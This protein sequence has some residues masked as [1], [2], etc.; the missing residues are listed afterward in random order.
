M[1]TCAYLAAAAWSGHLSP[2]A[3]RPLL[4]G[5]SGPIA[6][7]WVS[8]PP[9]LAS[10]NKE[11]TG[12]DFTLE[13]SEKGSR[14]GVF[15]TPDAQVT[16]ILKAGAFPPSPGGTKVQL[17][18]EPI[19]P[20]TLAGGPAKPFQIIGNAYRFAASYQPSGDAVKELGSPMELIL[21]Y[22]LTPNAHVTTHTVVSSPDGTS[23]ARAKGTDSPGNQTVEGPVPTLGYAAAAGDLTALPSPVGPSS[24]GDSTTLGVALI[25]GAVCVALVGIGL[26]ARGRTPPGASRRSGRR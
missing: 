1:V 19:D 25:V 21:V 4:D 3:R 5:L 7:N 13:V 2:L 22:P 11:P 23:W 14:A 20:A 17:T 9:E 26:L 8:P 15:T 12:G 24:G 6:Y 18:V 16:V 10:T